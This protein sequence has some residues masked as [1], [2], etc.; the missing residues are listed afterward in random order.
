M[1]DRSNL[2]SSLS[3]RDEGTSGTPTAEQQP[4]ETITAD[5]QDERWCLAW[6]RL[7]EQQRAGP[8]V[9]H[10]TKTKANSKD[11]SRIKA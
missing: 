1:F 8:A 3:W 4:P 10:F 11:V 2:K 9:V 6:L 7:P 5:E